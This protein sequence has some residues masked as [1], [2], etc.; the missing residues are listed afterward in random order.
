M[1]SP[2]H[3][4]IGGRMEAQRKYNIDL[5]RILA[6]FMVVLLHVAADNWY[7]VPYDSAE[8]M[9]FNFYDIATR[10][11][12]PIFF[13]ISGA[14]FLSK[15]TFSLKKLFCRNI[16]RLVF[17]YFLW[18]S[19]YAVDTIGLKELLPSLSS[20]YFFSVV[21]DSKY[22]LWYL[23]ELISIYFILPLLFAVK[24]IENGK[25]LKYILCLFFALE[26]L[27]AFMNVFP[28]LQEAKA[29][30]ER[31]VFPFPQYLGYFILGYVIYENIDVFKRIRSAFLAIGLVVIVVSLTIINYII[32][33]VRHVPSEMF[34]NSF[35]IASFLEACA[36]F[37][38]FLRIPCEKISPKIAPLIV[39]TSKYTLFVYLLHP[40]VLEHLN[41]HFGINSLC[42]YSFLSV[43]AISLAIFMICFATAF[44][45]DKIPF[46][47]KIFI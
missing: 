22:H 21:M 43:P 23:P 44:I 3:R 5:L 19:L 9:A 33:V 38:L 47:K 8:W 13:M 12:V 35:F 10:S 14:M 11:A 42:G 34:Y 32:S 24:N 29:V 7:Y 16:A 18:S 6:C 2:D 39:R 27:P 36:L 31:F 40:F 28:F 37:I 4:L 15:N 20:G 45:I 41:I 25:Y 17:I 1:I 46:I 30:I 26:I